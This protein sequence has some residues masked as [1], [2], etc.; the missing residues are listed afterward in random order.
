VP[1]KVDFQRSTAYYI[2]IDWMTKTSQLKKEG[3]SFVNGL[4]YIREHHKITLPDLADML[5]V[6][7]QVVSMWEQNKKPIPPKRIQQLSIMFNVPEKYLGEISDVEE[8]EIENIFL[9]KAID[10]SEVE[11]ETIGYDDEGKPFEYV[12]KYV[13]NNLVE[14]VDHNKMLINKKLLLKKVDSIIC[15]SVPNEAESLYEI[16]FCMD[17]YIKLFDK[18]ADVVA[19][20]VWFV[21]IISAVVRALELSLEARTNKDEICDNDTFIKSLTKSIL[22]E[23]EAQEERRMAHIELIK[24]LENDA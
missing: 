19:T 21:P 24:S 3:V 20:D 10:D 6:S 11:Y 18:F 4:R 17:N 12:D 1:K 2:A 23:Y 15:K 13:D 9:S 8:L 14:Y 16:I 22:V 5:K 7:K